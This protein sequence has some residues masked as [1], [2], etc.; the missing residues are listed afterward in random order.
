MASTK[1]NSK[2]KPKPNKPYPTFPLTVHPNGQWCKK[3]RG[4]VHFFGVWADPRGAL[5]EYTRQASDLHAGRAPDPGREGEPTVKDAGN[6]YLATQEAKVK[7]DLITPAWFHE[8]YNQNVVDLRIEKRLR[9]L[10]ERWR[11]AHS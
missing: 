9:T 8:R 2:T 5:E 6:S 1:T 4:K 10:G 11:F 3:I 7:R